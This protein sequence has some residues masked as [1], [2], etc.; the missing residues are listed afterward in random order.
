MG[1]ARGVELGQ[2][3]AKV[4][5]WLSTSVQRLWMPEGRGDS[6]AREPAATE[7]PSLREL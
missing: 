5:R 1:T 4:G 6:S 3:G 7:G 2:E